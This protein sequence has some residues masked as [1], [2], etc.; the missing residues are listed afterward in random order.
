[1]WRLILLLVFIAGCQGTSE[2]DPER[3]GTEG[4]VSIIDWIDLVKFNGLSYESAYKLVVDDPDMVGGVVGEVEFNVDKNVT[5]P[6]Y[7]MVSGDATYLDKD[8]KLYRIKGQPKMLAVESKEEING[9]K[10]YD[11]SSKSWHFKDLDPT[12]VEKIGLYHDQ[13]LIREIEGGRDI[14]DFIELINQGDEAPGYTPSHERKVYTM[15]FHT[16]EGVARQYRVYE[17]SN[18]WYWHPWDTVLLP[19]SVGEWFTLYE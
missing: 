15:V 7:Q 5:N 14:R 2:E 6:S 13:Q 3:Y 1:M 12:S 11:S 9:F 16:N 8:T 4:K 18:V 17:N 19:D 10:I